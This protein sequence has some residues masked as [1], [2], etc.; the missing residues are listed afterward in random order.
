[1]FLR[2]KRLHNLLLIPI[3]LVHSLFNVELT[4]PT[5]VIPASYFGMHFHH[6]LNGRTT[7]PDMPVPEWRLWD[8]YVT[9]PDIEPVKGQWHFGKL[10]AYVSMAEQHGTGI[11]LPLGMCP[12]WAS[13][14]P[15][16][17]TAGPTD[18]ADWGAFVRA[19]VTRYKG[20][21]QAYE[22]WNEPNLKSF[23]TG[24]M[25][26]MVALTKEA[27]Q[28]IHSVDPKVIVVSPAVTATYGVS[29]LADFLKKGG[30]QY[31][32]VIGYHFYITPQP[33][34]ELP[35]FIQSVKQV[36][37]ENNLGNKPLWNTEAGWLQ[38]SHFDS[39]EIAAGVLARSYILNWASGVQRYYWY[40]WDNYRVTLKTT[41]EDQTVT[42]AG[43]AYKV[44]EQWLVG[45]QMLGVT[46]NSGNWTCALDRRGKKQWI[47]WSP[48]GNR[49]FEVPKEWHI[50]N[51]TPLLHE[52][53]SLS[54]SNVDIGPA[55]VLLTGAA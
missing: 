22:I 14:H 48:D 12:V 16:D 39:D 10:D 21:I 28:I 17:V 37:A 23:W 3:L 11:L 7:W 26:Q 30:G 31:V 29:W 44:I 40:A 47:V 9:W 53:H 51:V 33:P 4:T 27:A 25:D 34:E 13:S 52:S 32:D 1:M 8:A 50:R 38:P 5:A 18:E 46:E 2:H 42:P 49:K 45:A 54:G 15:P 43:S 24:S 35:R 36:L 55:P 19:A 6:F 20:R 41:R